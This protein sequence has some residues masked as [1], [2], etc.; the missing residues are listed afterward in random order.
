[1]INEKQSKKIRMDSWLL[2]LPSRDMKR[3]TKV[4]VKV[5]S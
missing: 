5:K 3:K 1:M 2:K 4:K